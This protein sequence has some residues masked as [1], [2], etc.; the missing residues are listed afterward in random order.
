MLTPCILGVIV[1][2]FEELEDTRELISISIWSFYS[3]VQT[4]FWKLFVS[5]EAGNI[6]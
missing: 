2:L 4:E 5:K 1:T 6:T 3:D